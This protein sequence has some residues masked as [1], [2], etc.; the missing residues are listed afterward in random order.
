[1][2]D[3]VSGGARRWGEGGSVPITSRSL[4]ADGELGSGSQASS[5]PGIL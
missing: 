1:M 4:L 3:D 5:L 2:A